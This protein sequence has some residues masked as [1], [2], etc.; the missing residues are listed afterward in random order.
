MKHTKA[1]KR[2]TKNP[3]RWSHDLNKTVHYE[4]LWKGKSVTPGATLTL[5]FDRIKYRFLCLVHDVKLDLTWLE[6]ISD[7][8]FKSARIDRVSRVFTTVKRSRAKKDE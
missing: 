1:S 3:A 8:G 2:Y 7:E 6:L 4:F 5:K